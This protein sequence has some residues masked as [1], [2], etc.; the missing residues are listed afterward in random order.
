MKWKNSLVFRIGVAINI[1][2]LTGVL[3]ISAVYLWRETNHLE[4]KLKD[5]AITAANT[6]NSAIGLYMLE[7]DYAKISPLT[8]SLQ[9]E[10]NIAYVIVKDK[11][12]TTINQKGDMYTNPD[13]LIPVK[14]PLE[15]FQV[16]LGEV[17]IGLKTTSLNQQKR[18]LLSDTII[19]ALIYS[20]L[21]LIISGFISKKLTSPIKKLVIA[22]RKITN[23]DRNVKVIEEVGISEIRELADEFN[24]MALTIQNHENI[25]VNEINKATK[26]LSEKVEILEVLGDI[27]NSVLEDDIQSYEVIK[28]MLI[29]IKHYILVDHISFS[30][31]HHNNQIEIIQIDENE[32]IFSFEQKDDRY[33]V[34]LYV[35][36]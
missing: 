22:T 23:G 27:S 31:Q 9:S 10:P 36:S 8:Y 25:L 14:V 21:S 4:E 13:H 34:S 35:I 24:E 32:M 7:G 15:Y 30:F 28:N 1:L 29:S 20:L 11:E 16:Q 6:L 12:G 26:A 17:E 2:V 19:T 3:T 18:A 5:E 33:S